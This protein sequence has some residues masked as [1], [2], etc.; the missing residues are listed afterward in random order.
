MLR[1]RSR[2]LVKRGTFEGK[3]LA[4]HHAERAALK[5]TIIGVSVLALGCNPL[6]AALG[7]FNIALYY[8]VYTT[9]KRHTWW[10][11]QA[12]AIVGAI[13]PLMGYL[14]NTNG[15]FVNS[16]WIIPVLTLFW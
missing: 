10:N 4:L 1:T 6:V 11:T 12:G 9:L 16:M 5:S 7:A 15:E 14:T 13:P 3:Y 2:A 8:Q